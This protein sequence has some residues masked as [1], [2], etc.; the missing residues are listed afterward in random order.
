MIHFKYG[1]SIFQEKL[2]L[3]NDI[4]WNYTPEYFNYSLEYNAKYK[5]NTINVFDKEQLILSLLLTKG[6]DGSLSY[7]GTCGKFYFSR[8]SNRDLN[9]RAVKSIL[10]HFQDIKIARAF[11]EFEPVSSY[12]FAKHF[13]RLIVHKYLANDLGTSSYSIRKSYRSLINRQERE[14]KSIVIDEN[15]YSLKYF[16]DLQALHFES[17]GH[18]KTRSDYSWDLQ[19]HAV[20]TGKAL[21][22]LAYNSNEELI[23]GSL[24][25]KGD[26]NIYYGVSAQ[27]RRLMQE[28]KPAGHIVIKNAFDYAKKNNFDS[29]ILGRIENGNQ[30][31]SNILFFKEGFSNNIVLL[32]AVEYG[33]E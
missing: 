28:G 14:Y 1:F 16:Q 29:V 23:S 31:E 22:S 27:S 11:I 5:D 26:K 24:F 8:L 3:F 19:K 10:K 20:L 32:N 6:P 2:S 7:F 9:Y 15:N 25:L 33:F 13:L 30:K 12:L 18:V 21:L 4:S 17:A